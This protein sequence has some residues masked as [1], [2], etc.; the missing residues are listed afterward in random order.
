MI[1][2]DG[3]QGEGGGQILRSSLA[4]SMFTGKAF[5]IDHIRAGREKPGLLRQHLT[6]VNAAAKICSAKVDGAAL[7]SRSLAFEP[8]EVRSG[9]YHFA[10]G[11]AGSTTLVLQAILPPLLVAAGPSTVTLEG[12]THNPAAPPFEFF[13][14]SLVPL[15]NRMGPAVTVTLDR[16][17]FFP[18]GGGRLA[19]RVE[20]AKQLT[21]LHLPERIAIT[22]RSCTAAV[23][24]VPGEVAKRELDVIRKGFNWPESSFQIRQLPD[25]QGPGNVLMIEVGG[26]GVTEVVTAFGE[27]G[28][29]AEAVAESALRELKAYLAAD[30]PVGQHLADQILVPLAMA[31][32]GSFLTM[33][34]TSHTTTNVQIVREFLGVDVSL[35]DCR[36]GKWRAE[37]SAETGVYRQAEQ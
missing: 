4:L 25:D 15:L 10:I 12:G 9:D 2:L 35:S 21:P 23:A 31:G 5:R 13:E 26:D 29:R 28:V 3:S 8:R 6:A 22:H 18:A 36:N 17:G 19:A 7:G 1:T 14:K 27:R 24:A 34:P 30:A 11:T 33:H 16:A 20:P 32:G 37:V